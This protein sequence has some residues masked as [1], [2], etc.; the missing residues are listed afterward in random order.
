MDLHLKDKTVVVTGASRGIGLAVTQAFVEEGARVVAGARTTSPELAELAATG[1]VIPVTADLATA[2]GVETLIESAVE[3]LGGI[4]VLV[5][6]VGKAEPRLGGFASVTDEQWL[7]TLTVNL[8][9]AV[10]ASRAALPALLASRGSIVTISSV[11]AFLPDPG[12][13]DY[14]ASK[15]ALTNFSKALSK[16]VSPLG[17]RVN[18]VAPGPVTTPLWMGP[19]G[20]ADTL[21]TA[22]GVD[23][24]EAVDQMIDGLGGFAT[25]RF[26]RPDEV[27]DLVLMLASD[28]AANITG[29]DFTID[30]GLIKTL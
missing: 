14:T 9:S 5:N 6:N 3:R 24:Q 21:A 2:S 26:T 30:G 27:A 4:D 10:R 22:M 20:M 8:L 25:G 15:A 28:R 7:E 13:I 19:G 23:R 16:E 17:V 18:S 29:A 11:N 12:V 1:S